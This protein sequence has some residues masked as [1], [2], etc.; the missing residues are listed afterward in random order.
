MNKTRSG[1]NSGSR[2]IRDPRPHPPPGPP[3]IAKP[4]F[5]GLAILI[6]LALT[7]LTLAVYAPVRHFDFVN[8][9]DPIYITDNPQVANG[10]AWSGMKWAFTEGYAANWHPITWLSH[11]LDVEWYGMNAGLH[12][13]TNVIFHIANSLL[14]FGLLLRVAPSEAGAL[15]RSA[16]VAALFAVHPLHV[17]SVA[18]VSERKDVLSAFFF[19]VTLWAY[20]EYAR[21]PGVIRYVFV[22]LS[23]ALGLM[24]KP[25][26]VTVP[27]LLLLL[28][29]W[30]LRRWD[31][32]GPSG[33][34]R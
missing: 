29:F 15:G 10:L 20:V 18:W 16:L 33:Y 23:F 21:R 28:D 8:W 1:G 5:R 22:L 14:L 2:L 30:P 17:E 32:Q 19:M 25:M 13:V 34:S 31:G 12:H 6:G 9:D 27:F 26:L 4:S 24:A 11:M 3:A 7:L